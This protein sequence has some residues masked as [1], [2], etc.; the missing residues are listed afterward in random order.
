M[1]RKFRLRFRRF[2]RSNRPLFYFLVPVVS[3]YTICMFFVINYLKRD[4]VLIETNEMI[5]AETKKAFDK[6]YE[7]CLGKDELK[8]LENNCTER[9]GFS[10][11]L[12]ESLESLIMFKLNDEYK[13]ARE[14]VKEFSCDTLEHVD[15]YEFWDRFIPSLIGAY[16]LTKDSV[17][18]DLATKCTTN[19]IEIDTDIDFIPTHYNFADRKV[20]FNHFPGVTLP[21]E[22]SVEVPT[23]YALY[24]LTKND[25][26]KTRADDII[27]KILNSDDKTRYMVDPKEVGLGLQNSGANGNEKVDGASIS[28]LH[29]IATSYVLEEED[30]SIM[31]LLSIAFFDT[32]KESD[33]QAALLSPIFEACLYAERVGYAFNYE[34]TNLR[35]I[36]ENAYTRTYLPFAYYFK[37]TTNGF[38]YEAAALRSFLSEDP[39]DSEYINPRR[40]TKTIFKG[41]NSSRL[42]NGFSSFATSNS[43]KKEF[44]GIQDSSLFGE[45]T[46]AGGLVYSGLYKKLNNMVINEKGHILMK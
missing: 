22:K 28:F 45:W 29:H 21:N 38:H 25:D 34:Y 3:I 12:F 33:S 17:Y 23:L 26:I 20:L 16:L 7:T 9:F 41:L 37:T 11:S 10:S 44:T 8:P 36:L 13:K 40:I 19:A 27:Q 42:F 46:S 5:K 1:L 18:L 31:Q 35:M 24:K 30:S 6:Y 14:Y 32:I 4:K 15:R 2:Y 43:E 39:K